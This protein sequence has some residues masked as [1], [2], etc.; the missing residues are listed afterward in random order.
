V[1]EKDSALWSHPPRDGQYRIL[2]LSSFP[3]IKLP[4]RQ[5]QRWTWTLAV[6]GQWGDAQWVTW[7]DDMLVTSTHQ[8]LGQQVVSTPLG[9]LSC[10]VVQACATC[11]KGTSVLTTFY[12]P[13]YSFVRWVYRNLNGSR[14]ALDLVAAT[15]VA[16]SPTYFLPAEFQSLGPAA[17]H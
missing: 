16:A 5:G 1:L 14:I 7:Q 11:K 15:T 17:T 10:W 12:H 8:T 13:R 3:Y 4:A 6:G 9:P 2:Q